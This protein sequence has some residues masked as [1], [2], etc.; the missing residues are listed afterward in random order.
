MLVARN[1]GAGGM[2]GQ[3]RQTHQGMAS[4]GIGARREKGDSTGV[5][6]AYNSPAG[7]LPYAAPLLGVPFVPAPPQDIWESCAC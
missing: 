7:S 2:S 6:T 3:R 5:E 4:E 1:D